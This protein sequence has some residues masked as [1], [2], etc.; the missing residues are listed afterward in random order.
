[1]G[2]RARKAQSVLEYTIILAAIIAAVIAGAAAFRTKVNTSMGDA[3]DILNSATGNLK[4]QL[5]GAGG[6]PSD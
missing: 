2:L 4:S 6:T 1:M 5:S 3:G